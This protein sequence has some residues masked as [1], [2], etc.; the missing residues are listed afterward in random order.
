MIK[1]LKI[2]IIILAIPIIVLGV[3]TMFFP[4]TMIDKWGLNPIGNTGLN[5]LRSIFPGILL[6]SAFMIILGLWKKNSTWLLATSLILF[7]VAFGRIVSFIMDGFDF[8]SLPPTIYE[9]VL[10]IILIFY[11]KKLKTEDRI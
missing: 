7:V 10:G 8:N 5:S 6:G 9:V 11:T 4:T 3:K 1:G 2:L